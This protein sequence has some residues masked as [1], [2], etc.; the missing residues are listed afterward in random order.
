MPKERASASPQ[1]PTVQEA[2]EDSETQGFHIDEQAF[3]I[4]GIGSS[5]GGFEA[6]TK[7]FSLLPGDTGMG[8]VLVQHLAPDHESLIPELLARHSSMPVHSITDKTPVEPN[9]VYVIPPNA[10]LT[11]EGGMLRVIPPVQRHGHRTPIDHFF[12]S[13][14]EDQGPCAIGLIFSG[15][16]SDGTNGV[17]ALKEH[18]GMTMAQS[19]ETA[20]FVSMPKSAILTG[21]IDHILPVEQM[22]ET[23][24]QY[25]TFLSDLRQGKGLRSL[26]EETLTR[27]DTICAHLRRRT[28]HDF[29]QYRRSTI[30]RRVQRRMQVLHM[31]SPSQYLNRLRNNPD[32]ANQLLQDLLIGVTQFF[33]D[34]KTF[35]ALAREVIPQIG[36]SKHEGASLRIWVAGCSTGEEVYSLAMLMHEYLYR[37]HMDLTVQIFATDIDEQALGIARLGQYPKKI[38]DDVT[39]D[40]LSR[41]FEQDGSC[42]RVVKAIRDVCVFSLHNIVADPPFSRMDLISCRNMLIYMN[43]DLQQQVLSLFNY[44]L[45]KEGYLLLGSSEHAAGHSKFF[46]SVSKAHRI[47]QAKAVLRSIPIDL[48]LRGPTKGAPDQKPIAFPRNPEK[49]IEFF[50]RLLRQ[51]YGPPAVLIDKECQ[52]QYISGQTRNYLELPSGSLNLNVIQL[53]RPEL[54][55]AVRAGIFQSLKTGKE[56][57]QEQIRFS[58]HKGTQSVDIIVRP[59]RHGNDQW[60]LL[61]VV[62]REQRPPA[63][64]PKGVKS[65]KARANDEPLII[66]ELEQEIKTIRDYLQ[67][68]VDELEAS[69]QDLKTSN[70]EMLSVNEELQSANEELQTSKEELQSINEELSTVNSQL[71]GKVEELDQS[72][73]EVENLFRTTDIATLFLDSALVIKQFTPAAQKIFGFRDIDL[74]RPVAELAS[75]F[76]DATLVP[77]IQEVLRTSTSKETERTFANDSLIYLSR[78]IPFRTQDHGPE[79][80]VLTF[81]DIT[82][83]RKAETHA[84]DVSRQHHVLEVVAAFGQLAIQER[85]LDHVMDECVRQLGGTLSV[86]MANVLEFL[87]DKQ[88]FLLCA[89]IGWKEGLVG[90]AVVGAGRESQPGYTLASNEPVI[91]TDLSQETRFSGSSLLLDHSVVSGM[92]CLIRDQDGNPLGVLGVHSSTKKSFSAEDVGFLQTMANILAYAIHRK[93]VEIQLESVKNSLESRV[94]ERT[95]A[96]VHHQQRI[97][98]LSSELLLTEQRERRRISTELH[99]YLAQ[100]LVVGKIKLSQL[101]QASLSESQAPLVKEIEESLDE[102]LTYTRDLM[103]Q[104]S[105]PILY[106]FGLLAALG[107]LADKM[108]RYDLRVTVTSHVDDASLPLPESTAVILYQV[109]RELLFNVVKHAKIVNAGIEIIQDSPEVVCIEVSD[110]GC[111]FDQKAILETMATSPKFGLLNVQER[112]E[113]LGGHCEIQSRMGEGTRVRITIPY[114]AE[115]TPSKARMPSSPIISPLVTEAKTGVI[116]VVLADD[117]PIFREGLGTLLN[118]C[119]DIQVVGEAENGEQAVELARTLQPDVVVMDINMPVMNGIE[120]T[121]LIKERQSS[122]YVIGLSM[123]SDQIVR[124]AFFEAGGDEYVTKGDSFTSFAEVIRSSQG[125]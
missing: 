96:L 76:V 116:R 80:V 37:E 88:A 111:G 59:I 27:L 32:E 31:N 30:V 2:T 18:G 123:H 119:L 66:R 46:R 29:R 55:M 94:Q 69:N 110:L 25:G 78:I 113:G 106:E 39:A 71:T 54:R 43:P 45:N 6:F 122:A 7:F 60:E 87:P 12:M 33:R 42:Y 75:F 120:A 93:E 86:E 95:Q 17:R 124:K 56:I 14:A 101:Q 125:K 112:M 83:I 41:F 1:S 109:V 92:S 5:A 4:V 108:S 50:D 16:G 52:V 44:A 118:A 79:G 49:T 62:F 28:G 23:L 102:A 105:P 20:K 63:S 3:P 10:D 81:V 74:G 48:P 73:A 53:V 114:S 35:E 61:M 89:G 117:H 15:A 67:S 64:S 24:K 99:D 104:I 100:L 72:H 22:P 40:R 90:H 26:G 47:F 91:V 107:W 85:D 11:I 8:F 58:T 65:R 9:H 19:E 103:A 21:L 57:L 121:R 13:L 98:N 36:K 115:G 97:R 70:E 68:A 82:R 77:D 38:A 51:D 34:P 84:G